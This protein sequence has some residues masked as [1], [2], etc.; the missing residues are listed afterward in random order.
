M[1]SIAKNEYSNYIRVIVLFNCVL[2]IVNTKRCIRYYC[3]KI[4]EIR[5]NNDFQLIKIWLTTTSVIHINANIY[6]F[7]SYENVPTYIQF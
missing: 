4:Y 7:I 3:L 2:C 1:Y 6:Q 5:K